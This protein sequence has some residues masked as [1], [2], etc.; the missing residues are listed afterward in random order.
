MPP[1]MDSRHRRRMADAAGMELAEWK[2]HEQALL[3]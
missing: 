1:G 2:A 3:F